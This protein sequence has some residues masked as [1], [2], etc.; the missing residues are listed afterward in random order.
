MQ[1]S[2]SL[3]LLSVLA[4]YGASTQ[5]RSIDVMTQNQYLGA[6][7]TPVIAAQDAPS[8]NAAVLTALASIADNDFPTRAGLLANLIARRYPELVGLQEV[9]V[10]ECQ[11]LD[12]PGD[13]C[14]DASIAGAFN[15]HLDLTLNAL[16]RRWSPYVAA[17]SVRNLVLQIPVELTGDAKPDILVTVTDHDVILAR[18]DI[19]PHVTPVSFPDAACM[20]RSLDGCNFQVVAEVT[21][22]IGPPIK[23]ERGWVGVDAHVR[24]Q[25]YRFINTHLEVM[26][27]D[28][29]NP[30]SPFIQ[31]A[32]MAELLQ[33]LGLTTP[34]NRRLLVVG[35]INSSLD[36]PVIPG[37]FPVPLPPPFDQGITPPYQQLV[38][39]GYTDAW[40]L[41]G[42]RRGYTCCQL[43]DLSNLF[44]ILDERIDVIF[45]RERPRRTF[46]KRVLGRRIAEK[47]SPHGLWPSDHASVAVLLHFARDRQSQLPD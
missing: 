34:P 6:D 29:T 40:S 26:T 12:T 2:L 21:P 17:A 36:D 19:A 47:S 44:S 22:P 30:L 28:P 35:D 42:R 4:L 38:D 43:A 24:G 16:N 7:L 25:R 27:P 23:V 3:L 1:R 9:F 32:Q 15:N 11:D 20:Y 31:A 8:F 14:R 37:P 10:F 33:V 18:R 5:A 13:H 46:R 39:A 45:S 41:R